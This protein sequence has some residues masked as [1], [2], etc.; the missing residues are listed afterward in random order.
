M[1]ISAVTAV[2]CT[3]FYLLTSQESRV[4]LKTMLIGGPS[5]PQ[6][7]DGVTH[8][9]LWFCTEDEEIYAIDDAL[10]EL[11]DVLVMSEKKSIPIS[12]IVDCP[13]KYGVMTVCYNLLGKSYKACYPLN[14]EGCIQFPPY[15]AEELNQE[16]SNKKGFSFKRFIIQAQVK[17]KSGKMIDVTEELLE[18]SGPKGNFYSD[19]NQLKNTT[20][21]SELL[22]SCGIPLDDCEC[23]QIVD[24][25]GSVKTI[26]L[27]EDLVA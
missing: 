1:V 24:S 15:T 10:E 5:K 8:V 20:R 14:R 18:R 3:A 7:D 25:H 17:S 19:I 13:V 27:S 21:L 6:I 11:K 12:E 22:F 9:E 2:G 23:L 4:V 16:E 26:H